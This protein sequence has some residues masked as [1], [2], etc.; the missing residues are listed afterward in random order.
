MG[1]LR[2]LRAEQRGRIRYRRD[3]GALPAANRHPQTGI[4]QSGV[5]RGA[6]HQ[7][8]CGQALRA[9]VRAGDVFEP[10]RCTLRAIFAAGRSMAA[11]TQ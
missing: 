5:E 1:R 7:L 2:R 9:H 4:D 10:T 11:H 6:F 3:A 8:L